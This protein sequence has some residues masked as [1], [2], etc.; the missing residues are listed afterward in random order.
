[1]MLTSFSYTVRFWF[2][3]EAGSLN[4]TKEPSLH[5]SDL[6]CLYLECLVELSNKTSELLFSLRKDFKILIGFFF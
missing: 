5:T 6:H 1:M 2:Q 3:S 4:D